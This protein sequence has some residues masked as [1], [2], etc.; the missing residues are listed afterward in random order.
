MFV[1]RLCKT[2]NEAG[3]AARVV[4]PKHLHSQVAPY[5]TKYLSLIDCSPMNVGEHI[6]RSLLA[7][8]TSGIEFTYEATLLGVPTMFLPP[9]NATQ[10]LQLRYYQ[11]AFGDCIPF[12]LDKIRHSTA[13]SLDS[14]TDAIQQ[15]GMCGAWT[16]QF[17]Q[18]G[19]CLKRTLSGSS[20]DALAALQHQQCQAVSSVGSDGAGTIAAHILS[21][22]ERRLCLK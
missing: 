8:T 2:L 7:L 21:K 5:V 1:T 12:P 13:Q 17:E 10:L 15:E 9:F 20:L 4:L 3:L 22:I 11:D 6:E 18:L 19:R 14:D 16:T